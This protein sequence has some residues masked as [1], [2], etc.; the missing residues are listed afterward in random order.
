MQ[1]IVLVG[2]M[3]TGKTVVAK[4]LSKRLDMKYVSVDDIIEKM[5]NASINDIFSRKGE[6]Y[7]RN[8]EKIAVRDASQMENAVIDTGGGVVMDP[9]NMKNL[10]K[11][12][13]IVCLWAEPE[14]ILERTKKYA[15]RPLL[16]VPDPMKNIRELMDYRKPFYKTAD[17]HIDTSGKSIDKVLD[18]VE[19]IL[20]NAL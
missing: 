12:G 15:D 1:N 6:K 10:K 17:H 2:F 19:R 5:E 11:R 8:L 14:T 16:N 20:K 13:V 4:G 7:F 9:E 18:D 3:G